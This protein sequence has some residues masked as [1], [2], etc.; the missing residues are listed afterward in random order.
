MVV[1]ASEGREATIC[2]RH[3]ESLFSQEEE[4]HGTRDGWVGADGSKHGAASAAGGAPL[5]G[6]RHVGGGRGSL[7]EAGRGRL[8]IAGGAGAEAGEAAHGVADGSGGSG[9]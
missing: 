8:G 7:G 2:F 1:D 6:V 9:G 3:P 5:R 4:N